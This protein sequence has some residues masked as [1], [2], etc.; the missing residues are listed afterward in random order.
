MQKRGATQVQLISSGNHFS[1]AA[2]YTLEAYAFIG[3]H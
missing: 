1:T 2:S 3:Q